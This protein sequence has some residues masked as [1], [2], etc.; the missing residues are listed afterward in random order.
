[1]WPSLR[2]LYI[3]FTILILPCLIC[4]DYWLKFRPI[5]IHPPSPWRMASLQTPPPPKK[6]NTTPS[7]VA[8]ASIP[9]IGDLILGGLERSCAGC[10][11]SLGLADR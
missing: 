5:R 7:C 2:L 10:G 3:M 1:M 11:A 9:P 6:K 8:A 4:T